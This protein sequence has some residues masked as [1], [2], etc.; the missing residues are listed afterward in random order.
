MVVIKSQQKPP[1]PKGN[2]VSK[3]KVYDI[4]AETEAGRVLFIVARLF[5]DGNLYIITSYWA[6]DEMEEFYHKESEVLRDD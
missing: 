6:E 1:T 5:T 4:C 3:G 2:Q